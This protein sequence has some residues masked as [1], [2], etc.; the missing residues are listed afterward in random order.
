M[1]QTHVEMDSIH[2]S[3]ISLHT[4]LHNDKTYLIYI[5]IQILCC[6]NSNWAMAHPTSIIGPLDESK[7]WL[8][9]T[10]A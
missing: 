8:E 5:S 1:F 6:E 7:T 10:S 9:S 4:T 3:H 2:L